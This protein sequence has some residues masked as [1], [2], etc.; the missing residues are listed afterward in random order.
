MPIMGGGGG[1]GAAFNGGTI[2]GPLNIATTDPDVQPL[3]ITLPAGFFN[4][5]SFLPFSVVDENGTTL[6]ELD[7]DASVTFSPPA[8]ESPSLELSN[9]GQGSFL[10]TAN[11][12]NVA[13]LA[14]SL[15]APAGRSAALALNDPGGSAAHVLWS[16]DGAGVVASAEI[17][18][19]ATG[20]LAFFGVVPITQPAVSAT[21]ITLAADLLDALDALGLVNKTA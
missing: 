21:S 17:V 3:A 13:D 16:G 6:L 8:G 2:T 20:T 14:V 18:R 1:G 19:E 10:V 11:P 7:A 5:S 12:D 9:G 15:N 4:G